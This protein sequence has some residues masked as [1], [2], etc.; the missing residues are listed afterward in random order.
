MQTSPKQVQGLS[1]QEASRRRA[2]GQGNDAPLQTSRTYWDILRQNLFTFIN[3][4]YFFLSLVL[5][6]LGRA[7]DVLVLAVV[8][9]LNV[10]INLFQ[11]IRAKH[12]LD[13][14]ALITRPKVNVIRDGQE[15]EV[16]PS[17][18]VV[19]DVMIVRPGDQI[20]VDGAIVNGEMNVDESLLTGESDQIPKD[21][22]SLVFR[23]LLRQ[24]HCLLRSS[25]GGG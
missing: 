14:I 17:E 25:K 3:G 7:S 10:V 11:E 2:A 6:V 21:R 18:I 16:D 8:V 5:I 4:A 9:L 20:V 1:D 24:R 22:R 12:K 23:Q 13:R 15:R 19:G